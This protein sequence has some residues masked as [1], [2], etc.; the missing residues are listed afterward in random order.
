MKTFFF[1]LMTCFQENILQNINQFLFPR[2]GSDIENEL[3]I[4]FFF[5][6]WHV[7][8]KNHKLG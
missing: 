2:F 4:V 7:D 6:I 8:A 1:F 5:G 3:E